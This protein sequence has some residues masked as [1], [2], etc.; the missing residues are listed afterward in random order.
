MELVHVDMMRVSRDERI[1]GHVRVELRG[2]FAWR[3]AGG[4]LD[5]RCTP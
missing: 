3:D 2:T 1:G 5:Q 4:V